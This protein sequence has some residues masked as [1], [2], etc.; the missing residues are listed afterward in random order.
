M[1]ASK[2]TSFKITSKRAGKL[3]NFVKIALNKIE[4]K[5]TKKRRRQAKCV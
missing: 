3:Q 2:L 5:L 1:S 4:A